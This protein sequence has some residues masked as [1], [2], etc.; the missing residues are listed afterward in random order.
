[1]KMTQTRLSNAI[2]G[3]SANAINLPRAIF[4]PLLF[5][6]IAFAIALT[7]CS[8]CKAIQNPRFWR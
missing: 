1:M 2:D 3:A 8:T 4:T 7:D 6:A 5:A